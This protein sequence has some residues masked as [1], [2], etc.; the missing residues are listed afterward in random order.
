MKLNPGRP[1]P[2]R[3]EDGWLMDPDFYRRESEENAY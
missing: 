3:D 1:L 2:P